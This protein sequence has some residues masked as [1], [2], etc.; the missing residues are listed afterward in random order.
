MWP[1]E[2]WH[3]LL[4]IV[5][6]LCVEEEMWPHKYDWEL[7][8]YPG[9][10]TSYDRF[11]QFRP[12]T[13]NGI[14]IISEN[15][16]MKW[17]MGDTCPFRLELAIAPVELGTLNRVKHLSN[18]PFLVLIHMDSSGWCLSLKFFFISGCCASSNCSCCY[19]IYG[20]LN[21][22]LSISLR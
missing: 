20:L 15:A 16:I 4:S 8:Y 12:A 11:Q 14:M 7:D 19:I 22:G 10:W 21:Q 5:L 6:T 18:S 9:W 1:R 2:M 17:R 13:R 3:V